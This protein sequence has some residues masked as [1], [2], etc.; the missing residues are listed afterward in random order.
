MVRPPVRAWSGQRATCAW[1]PRYRYC[2][3]A[4]TGFA[5]DAPAACLRRFKSSRRAMKSF[6]R[7]RARA[8]SRATSRVLDRRIGARPDQQV[9]GFQPLQPRGKED[10]RLAMGPEIEPRLGP[11]QVAAQ[12]G[13]VAPHR[14]PQRIAGI[15]AALQK[16]PHQGQVLAAG[17][18][19]PQRRGAEIAFGLVHRHRS[20][21]RR[22]AFE[23][24][25]DGLGAVGLAEVALAGLHG[26]GNVQRHAPFRVGRLGER[27]RCL[28]HGLDARDIPAFCGI[29]QRS[30]GGWS[31]KLPPDCGRPTLLRFAGA[32]Q[33]V[34]AGSSA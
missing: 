26:A 11:Q 25:R 3:A 33:P 20:L 28:Q 5:R 16:K 8:M 32:I 21:Q 31:H 15:R 30:L 19:I 24:D 4:Y 27:G 29:E 9:Q 1:G 7:R 18:R 12:H 13:I 22:A 10:R 17:D 6:G 34:R 23:E 2:D 14:R